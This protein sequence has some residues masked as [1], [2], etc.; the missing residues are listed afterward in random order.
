M[1]ASSVVDSNHLG[2]GKSPFLHL[3]K[4]CHLWPVRACVSLSFLHEL[5]MAYQ[6]ISWLSHHEV[7]GFF[8]MHRQPGILWHRSSRTVRIFCWPTFPADR[9]KKQQCH[10]PLGSLCW[11]C[12]SHQGKSWMRKQALLSAKV[13]R[14][15]CHCAGVLLVW[16]LPV[17]DP[18]WQYELPSASPVYV[19][20]DSSTLLTNQFP[21]IRINE[22]S[23]VQNFMFCFRLFGFVV[24]LFFFLFE[25]GLFW[26][27][28]AILELPL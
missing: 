18:E 20:I 4:P 23:T 22:L 19:V 2:V 7:L 1:Y 21:G 9:C 10:G 15:K 24:F 12:W 25:T 26:V 16:L 27:T 28:L 6:M 14:W 13:V 5:N 8:S 17:W 3:S 11:V